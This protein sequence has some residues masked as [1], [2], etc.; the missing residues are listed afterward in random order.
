[1]HTLQGIAEAEGG[2]V[3]RHQLVFQQKAQSHEA[4]R[5]KGPIS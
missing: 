4:H 3:P 5:L 2:T 1:M